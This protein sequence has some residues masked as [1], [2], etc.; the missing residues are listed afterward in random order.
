[1]LGNKLNFCV[2]KGVQILSRLSEDKLI[3]EQKENASNQAP[4]SCEFR[5]F[6][7][8]NRVYI[9]TRFREGRLMENEEFKQYIIEQLN[10]IQDTKILRRIYLFIQDLTA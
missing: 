6:L 3:K 8:Y 9:K 1:V 2:V 4:K 10:R 7:A 5:R